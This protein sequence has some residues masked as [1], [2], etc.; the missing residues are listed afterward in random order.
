MWVRSLLGTNVEILVKGARMNRRIALATA[1]VAVVAAV[2][3]SIAMASSHA[4]KAMTPQAVRVTMI[5]YGFKLSK[6]TVKKGVP[7]IFT[8]LNKGKTVH[9]FDIQGFKSTPIA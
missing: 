5:D 4:T 9:N 1:L 6:T 2:S 3:A 7:V 8:V